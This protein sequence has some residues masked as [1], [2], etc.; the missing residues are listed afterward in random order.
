MRDLFLFVLGLVATGAAYAWYQ[1]T[2]GDALKNAKIKERWSALVEQ[3]AGHA[4]DIYRQANAYLESVRPPDVEWERRDLHAGGVLTGRRYDFLFSRNKRLKSFHL[5]LT[6]YDYGTS[7]HVAWFLTAEP[8]FLQRL[9]GVILFWQTGVRDDPRQLAFILD[10]PKQL[11]LS[12]YTTMLHRAA[13]DAV[14]TLMEQLKQD[15]S[16]ID[17]RS[18]GFLELW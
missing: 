17:T 13:K 14:K 11:E 2:Y 12:A 18:K 3:G 4:E 16:K 9:L 7:L 15:F 5:Y 1:K 6:A 10:I 8:T